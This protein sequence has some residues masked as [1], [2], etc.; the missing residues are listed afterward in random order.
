MTTILIILAVA[1]YATSALLLFKKEV[2]GPLA[3]FLALGSV[4]L[5]GTLPLNIN[6][7][8]TWLCITLVVTGASAMQAPAL[9]AQKRGM[10]Y[11]SLGALTGLAVGLLAYTMTTRLSAIYAI[12]SLAIVIGIF[13]GYVLFTRT[14]QGEQL[15]VSRSRFFPY[16]L[17]K[18]FPVAVATMMLGITLIIWIFQSGAAMTAPA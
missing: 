3:A 8:I 15:S 2:L 11:M 14:P 9:M 18:G 10:G 5:S 16:L 7:I 4:Y 12:M 13:F 1:L 17:A 6:M